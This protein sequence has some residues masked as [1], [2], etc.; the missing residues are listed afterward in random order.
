MKVRHDR[1]MKEQSN[2]L[3]EQGRGVARLRAKRVQKAAAARRLTP[4]AIREMVYGRYQDISF[5]MQG[6]PVVLY[7][8][9]G[10]TQVETAQSYTFATWEDMLKAPVFYGRTLAEAAPLMTV[11]EPGGNHKAGELW[12]RKGNCANDFSLQV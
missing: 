11:Q 2:A 6:K 5:E 10:S 12:R 3:K 1:K 7:A 9:A 4:E 8:D